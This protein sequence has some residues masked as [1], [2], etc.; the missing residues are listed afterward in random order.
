M[1]ERTIGRREVLRGAGVAVTGAAAM[2]GGVAMAAPAAAS[3]HADLSGS[4]MIM[5]LDAGTTQWVQG[6]VSFA[7][8][9]VLITHDINPAGPPFTG[10]WERLRGGHFRG[11]MWTGTSGQGPNTPGPTIRVRLM[12]EVEMDHISGTYTFTVLDPMTGAVLQS[13]TGKFH[14]RPITA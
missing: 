2:A 12:G 6:V 10:T 4:W 8:G 11:T 3:E 7:A 9:D 14:G 1:G 13:G 5:R